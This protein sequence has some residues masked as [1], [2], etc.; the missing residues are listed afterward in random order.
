MMKV[1]IL[2][3]VMISGEPASVGSFHEVSYPDGNLLI[4]C[5]KAKLATEEPEPAKRTRKTTA[6]KSAS[7]ED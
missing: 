4:N 2:R 7:E 1:E 3:P 6:P 5:G